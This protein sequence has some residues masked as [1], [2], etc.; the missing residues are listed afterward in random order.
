M[1]AVKSG[2]I[3]QLR[4]PQ[5]IVST[6]SDD[7]SYE[8]VQEVG[9]FVF[10]R[11]AAPFSSFVHNVELDATGDIWVAVGDGAGYDCRNVLV[12]ENGVRYDFAERYL[13]DG[14]VLL[15]LDPH[16]HFESEHR[17]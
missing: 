14:P 8:H 16:R 6:R 11:E 9:P 13:C 12:E 15:S 1:P 4:Q 2:E 3:W 17:R 5:R 10:I 7:P